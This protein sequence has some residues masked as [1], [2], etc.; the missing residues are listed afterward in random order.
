MSHDICPSF[1]KTACLCNFVKKWELRILYHCN[2]KA[3]FL[4]RSL[5]FHKKCQSFGLI[6]TFLIADFF[7]NRLTYKVL[8]VNHFLTSHS[9]HTP[10]TST[11]ITSLSARFIDRSDEHETFLFR[12]ETFLKFFTSQMPAELLLAR[13]ISTKPQRKSSTT[14]ISA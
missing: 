8:L 7:A 3:M 6:V 14:L 1:N 9:T 2:Y 12:I 13:T 5:N 4:M 10:H 11:R